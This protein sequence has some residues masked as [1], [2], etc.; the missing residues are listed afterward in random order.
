MVRAF[1]SGFEF[2]FEIIEFVDLLCPR[3]VGLESL[4]S[5]SWRTVELFP[6]PMSVAGGGVSPSLFPNLGTGGRS[7]A[8]VKLA[9]LAPGVVG[10]DTARFRTEGGPD[11]VPSFCV[12]LEAVGCLAKPDVNREVDPDAA[13][14]L[15]REEVRIVMAP[16]RKFLLVAGDGG[17]CVGTAIDDLDGVPGIDCRVV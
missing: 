1:N 14:V 17:V 2:D 15:K 16:L 11:G 10:V 7:S 13:T 4:L 6:F 8:G 5:V 12:E 3:E 9:F